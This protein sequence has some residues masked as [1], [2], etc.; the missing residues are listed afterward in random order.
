MS[1]SQYELAL[2]D[3]TRAA[4]LDPQNPKILMRLGRIFVSLGNPE[5]ALVT[6][7][8]IHPSPAAR[9]V[10]PAKEQLHHVRAAQDALRG[11]S[12]GS[13][14]LHALNQAERL[15]G[16]GA[17]KPR[18]WQLMRGEAYIKIGDQTSL[19]EAQ[20]IA[21]SLLRQNN[22]DPEALVLRG[23]ILYTMGDNSK[24]INFL[25]M[26]LTCDPEFKDAIK[27][28][29]IIQKLDRMKESGNRE[30]KAGRWQEAIRLYSEALEID[31]TNRGINSKL[32]GNRATCRIKLK[33]YEAAITDCERAI[34]LDS[35]YVK[36]HKTKANALGLAGQWEEAV[37]EWKAVQQLDPEDRGVAKEI[38][39]AE[40]ELKKSQRKDYYKILGVEKSADDHAIKR[41]YR[42]L[43]IVHHPDK[44][45]GNK[46]AEE[47]FKDISEAYDTLSDPQ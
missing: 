2:K 14:V 5:D 25:R 41:A 13:M 16:S 47:R 37:R 8:R 22:Q 6:F 43:A 7:N 29:R 35:K 46:E 3:C 33:D 9:D 12:K 17:A 10:A 42:K 38:R 24:A 1:N 11:E 40:I 45:Q 15:Q 23:R 26:A 20:N 32:L 44:N 39:N 4:D 27:W 28:L 36:A 34:K 21:M 18:K 19:G 31:I 30:F